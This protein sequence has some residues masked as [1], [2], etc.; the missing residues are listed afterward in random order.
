[1]I[2]PDFGTEFTRLSFDYYT[3][4]PPVYTYCTTITVGRYM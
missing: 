3:L 4:D 2:G 1:M